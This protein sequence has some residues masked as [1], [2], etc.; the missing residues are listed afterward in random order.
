[1]VKEG[2]GAPWKCVRKHKNFSGGSDARPWPDPH[3]PSTAASGGTGATVMSGWPTMGTP[4]PGGLNT[5]KEW[6]GS[7]RTCVIPYFH[8]CYHWAH[9]RRLEP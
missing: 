6:T 5:L 1:M 7:R 9:G 4:C 3:G 2:K 8:P